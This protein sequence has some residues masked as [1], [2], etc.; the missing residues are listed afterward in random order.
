MQPGV[1]TRIFHGARTAADQVIEPNEFDSA[2]ADP[3]TV[4]GIVIAATADDIVAFEN[5]A[6]IVIK[7][8]AV[9]GDTTEIDDI[10]WYADDGLVFP[11]GLVTTTL[12]VNYRPSG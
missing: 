1:A 7:T 3:I 2:V 10:V 6:G 12:T 4:Y 5:T 11:L 8:I 9:L